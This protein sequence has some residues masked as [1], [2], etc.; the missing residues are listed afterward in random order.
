MTRDVNYKCRFEMICTATRKTN[1]N[2]CRFDCA[3]FCCLC[4]FGR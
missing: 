1:E 3:G 4:D 2:A